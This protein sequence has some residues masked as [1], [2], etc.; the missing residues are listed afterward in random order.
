MPE[1]IVKRID[2][3]YTT[4]GVFKLVRNGKCQFDQFLNDINSDNNLRPELGDIYAVI[5]DVANC[6]G[7]LPQSKYRKLHL[8][9]KVA[10][11]GYEVKSKHLR[12]YLFHDKGTGQ[13]IVLGGKKV[14]QDKDIERF[15]KTIREYTG[16]KN[17]TKKEKQ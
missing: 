5:E 12:V 8:S 4:Q 15:E 17:S 6:N 11:T 7:L 1:F 13:I 14:N 9:Q 10:F 2:G 3:F 16:Y